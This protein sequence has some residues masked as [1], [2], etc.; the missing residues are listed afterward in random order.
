MVF[1]F[2][3]GLKRAGHILQNELFFDSLKVTIIIIIV[4][5]YEDN[6]S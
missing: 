5:L 1:L 4:I 6:F 3:L 2:Y